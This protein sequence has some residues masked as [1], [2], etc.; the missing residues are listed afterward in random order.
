[1]CKGHCDLLG[2]GTTK[3]MIR[4]M[5]NATSALSFVFLRL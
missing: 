3:R 5:E 2:T 4:V 1:M